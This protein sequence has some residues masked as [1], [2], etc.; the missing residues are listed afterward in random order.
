[1][2]DQ[3]FA[4]LEA[5]QGS[6]PWGEVLD[7]GTGEHSLRWIMG[8]T[9][10]RWTAV[11]GDVR[12]KNTLEAQFA[13]QMRSDDRVVVG[14]WRDPIMLHNERYDVV[15]ADYLIGA[16]DG[17]AP[18]FQDQLL[19]R[20]RPFVRGRLY[21]VGLEPYPDHTPNPGGAL[22][23]EIARLRDACIL[24][25]GHRCYREYPMDWVIR[26]LGLAG[27]VVDDAI[28]MPILYSERFIRSQLG[29]CRRKLPHFKDAALAH[30][31]GQHIDTLEKRALD[32][33]STSGRIGF[34][35]D[36]LVMARP[37]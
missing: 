14:N 4:Q 16:I 22:I 36:Y 17:F 31:M 15:L 2:G 5:W 25:A 8:L 18:Y 11:T 23:L 29:V 33:L 24:L 28:K 27:F 6:T 19:T 32:W 26:Q 9:T 3:L 12:R 7:A 37:V 34:G 10:T 35:E 20:L 30:Q 21:I 1:M 13:D